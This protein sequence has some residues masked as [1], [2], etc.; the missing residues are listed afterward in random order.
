MRSTSWSEHGQPKGV[1]VGHSN[2]VANVAGCS[3]ETRAGSKFSTFRQTVAL[4]W[5]PTFH[6]MVSRPKFNSTPIAAAAAAH[7]MQAE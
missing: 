4:S 3:E 7:R 6:D 1:M 2:I 5:L